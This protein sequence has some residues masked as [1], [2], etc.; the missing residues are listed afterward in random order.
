MFLKL[1]LSVL[2]V[3]CQEAAVEIA[4][5]LLFGNNRGA[6]H[7]NYTVSLSLY[8]QAVPADLLDWNW[9]DLL[10]YFQF[11]AL[12]FVIYEEKTKFLAHLKY[13]GLCT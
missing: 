3:R 4:F 12:I 6:A 1:L 13:P 7:L 2:V 10:H 8:C 5:G 11:A 9:A